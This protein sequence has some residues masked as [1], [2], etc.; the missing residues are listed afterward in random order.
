[1]LTNKPGFKN[2]RAIGYQT[3]APYVSLSDY[4]WSFSCPK[5]GAEVEFLD[6]TFQVMNS[7][8][9]I[10]QIDADIEQSSE[11]VKSVCR[12]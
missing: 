9:T 12:G 8:G 10:I 6:L 11:M 1:M 7:T 5:P 3:D 4:C 2:L